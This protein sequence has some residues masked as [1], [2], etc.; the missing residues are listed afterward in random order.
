MEENPYRAPGEEAL[1]QL[2]F[3]RQLASGLLFILAI[4][5][6]LLAIVYAIV[7]T[8]WLIIEARGKG[9]HKNP[10]LGVQL[11]LGQALILGAAI[12]IVIAASAW[13]GAK[14]MR[15]PRPT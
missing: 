6:G 2:S 5:V 11:S 7:G 3:W 4:V 13:F 14:R 12:S 9:L 10:L 8:R 1:P 15:R